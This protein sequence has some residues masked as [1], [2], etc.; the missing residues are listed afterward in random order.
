[1]K[2]KARRPRII[3]KQ[4]AGPRHQV[5]VIHGRKDGSKAA[6]AMPCATCPWRKDAVGAF[7]AQAFRI[8]APT[9]YDMA[10]QTF[11]CHSAG[12]DNPM[13]CAG[14]V[15]HGSDHNLRARVNRARGLYRGVSAGGHALFKS[16]REMAVANGV[17]PD[18]TLLQPCL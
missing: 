12:R 16:Y 13:D 18:D 3:A 6:C 15:L 10:R 2:K 17:A 11:A 14:F 8:S 4:K 1:V 9:A 7:P 5:L